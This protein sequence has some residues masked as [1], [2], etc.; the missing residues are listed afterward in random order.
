M[1]ASTTKPSRYVI[2][3][4]GGSGQRMGSTTPKQ[5]LPVSGVPILMHTIRRFYDFDP[6]L[7]II[8]VL[9][10]A[11]QEEWSRLCEEYNFD[12]V[13]NVVSG[14]D[15]R[16]QSSKNGL[17]AI[18][19]DSTGLVAIHD[20]VRPF[21]D[22][23][24]IKRCFDLA[25]ETG[26]VV[27]VVPVVDTLRHIDSTGTSRSV[28]RSN[29]L[30]AQTPQVFSLEI[31]RKAFNQPFCKSFTDDASVVEAAGYDVATTEGNRENIKITTPF[32]LLVAE[33]I[34]KNSANERHP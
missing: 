15:T 21:V 32:D 3:V 19:K 17:D 11:Q 25:E 27:P 31:A 26:A 2:I 33:Q 12:V 13:H 4:A 28:Q 8:V 22:I 20:G 30:A 14:G 34:I 29:Y 10:A 5:F 23:E 7:S 16:F 1:H 18:P 6:S 24:T 9:P